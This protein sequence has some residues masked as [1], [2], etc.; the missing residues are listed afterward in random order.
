[1]VKT[2]LLDYVPNQ[3]LK[4]PEFQEI[5]KAE[6]VEIDDLNSSVEELL[7][8]QFVHSATEIGISRW[9]GILKL[10]VKKI[11]TLDDRRFRILSHLNQSLPYTYKGL[12]AQLKNLGIDDASI[13]LNTNEYKLTVKIRLD[14]KNKYET[15]QTLLDNITPANLIIQLLQL[16]NTHAELR[17]FKH[18]DLSVYTHKNIEEEE[19]DNARLHT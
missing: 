12:L 15:V 6:E 2:A 7:N 9:E 16:F 10:A 17:R 1:M 3:M 14:L 8:N 18:R 13:D 5:A 11:D 19:V 4:L